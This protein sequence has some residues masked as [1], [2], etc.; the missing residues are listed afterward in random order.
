[1]LMYHENYALVEEVDWTYAVIQAVSAYICAG[2]SMISYHKTSFDGVWLIFHLLWSQSSH[3]RESAN[4]YTLR[5]AH[6]RGNI[7]IYPGSYASDQ[8]GCFYNFETPCFSRL[9]GLTDV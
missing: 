6:M 9:H 7:A 8:V 2:K 4:R 5:D 1:M 3:L